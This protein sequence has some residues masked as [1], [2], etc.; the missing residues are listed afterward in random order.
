[1]S[2]KQ[3]G[4]LTKGLIR[5]ICKGTQSDVTLESSSCMVECNDAA[6]YLSYLFDPESYTSQEFNLAS[7]TDF[8]NVFLVKFMNTFEACQIT[9]YMVMFD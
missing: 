4:R 9:N 6:N 2:T 7:G 3:F 5:G 1:M 8:I